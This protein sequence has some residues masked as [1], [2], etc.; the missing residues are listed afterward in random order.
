MNDFELNRELTTLKSEQNLSATALKGHQTQIADML[1]GAMG[2]DIRDV[3]SGKKKVKLSFWQKLRYKINFF[4]KLFSNNG[5]QTR[6]GEYN[7]IGQ[8]NF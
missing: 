6:N 4:L 1:N 8:Y 5:I 3:L 7:G 2:Q